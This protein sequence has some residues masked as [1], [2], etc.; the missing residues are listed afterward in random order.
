MADSWPL[1][2]VPQFNKVDATD[3]LLFIHNSIVNAL[4]P[5]GSVPTLASTYWSVPLN[6]N[7]Y[8]EAPAEV[9]NT[10]SPLQKVVAPPAAIEGT[11]LLTNGTLL[12]VACTADLEAD[13]QLPFT[14]S[15]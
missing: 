9:S 10:E 5:T 1:P 8:P 4:P 14:A 15:T 6:C 13:T 3:E 7:A 11:A 2:E 12:I